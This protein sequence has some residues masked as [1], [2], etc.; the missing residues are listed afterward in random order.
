LDINNSLLLNPFHYR[1]TRK[2]GMLDEAFKHLPRAEILAN[3]GIQFMQ[4]DTLYQ[5]LA[6][7]LQKST[8]LDT[9]QTLANIPDLFNYWLSGEI[10]NEFTHA[11]TTQCFDPR[12]RDWATPVLN[13]LNIP[14]HLFGPVTDLE[15]LIRTLLPD[16]AEETGSAESD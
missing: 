15:T 6:M 1:D 12:K 16:I 3:T 4:I 10:T 14:T 2:D 7:S 13:A 11:T 9:G 5:L 8:A